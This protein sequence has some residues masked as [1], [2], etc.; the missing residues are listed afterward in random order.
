ME[1]QGG[2]DDRG[3][4]LRCRQDAAGQA[5]DN[6]DAGLV[7]AE[8]T[9][10]AQEDDASQHDKEVCVDSDG[11]RPRSAEERQDDAA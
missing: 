9:D 5:A 10:G 11:N 4:R 7:E 6:A 3:H 2:D 1:E 8:G